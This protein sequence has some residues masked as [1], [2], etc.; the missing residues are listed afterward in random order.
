MSSVWKEFKYV[1]EKEAEEQAKQGNHDSP[2]SMLLMLWHV[3]NCWDE[4]Y[5]DRLVRLKEKISVNVL[6]K[7]AL[8]SLDERNRLKDQMLLGFDG[9]YERDPHIKLASIEYLD[10]IVQVLV[11]QFLNSQKFAYLHRITG[12]NERPESKLEIVF[13]KLV[14]HFI[15]KYQVWVYVEEDYAH[16]VRAVA[17]VEPPGRQEPALPLSKMTR[18]ALAKAIGREFNKVIFAD[19]KK[20]FEL[21]K[22]QY[23]SFQCDSLV[24][25]LFGFWHEPENVELYH[26]AL[27]VLLYELTQSTLPNVPVYA[28]THPDQRRYLEELGFTP[29]PNQQTSNPSNSIGYLYVR[30]N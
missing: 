19:L 25:H 4:P 28:Q 12:V 23:N 5:F 15:E 6:K 10:S 2:I 24:I 21:R 29:L 30:D 16:T 11:N 26:S 1:K 9:T 8:L 13:Y 7:D 27:T 22:T 3:Y 17:L 14:K 20:D 18:L